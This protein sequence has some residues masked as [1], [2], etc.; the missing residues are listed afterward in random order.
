MA[1]GETAILEK[2]RKKE[3]NLNGLLL[4]IPARFRQM[5]PE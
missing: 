4:K 1:D 3:K 5:E 2:K